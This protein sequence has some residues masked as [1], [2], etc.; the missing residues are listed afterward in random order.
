[1]RAL[2]LHF[3]WL[4]ISSQGRRWAV[5]GRRWTVGGGVKSG[6]SAA[7]AGIYGLRVVLFTWP[8]AQ[9]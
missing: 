9:N 3:A 7:A 1:M 6:C 5:G 8:V 2:F 4:V